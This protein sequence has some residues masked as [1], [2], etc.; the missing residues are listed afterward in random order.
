MKGKILS[1]AVAV[2]RDERVKEQNYTKTVYGDFDPSFSSR[3]LLQ[4]SFFRASD[5]TCTYSK[6]PL[7]WL[8]PFLYSRLQ[9]SSMMRGFSIRLK[10]LVFFG[11]SVLWEFLA[12]ESLHV[13]T[14]CIW[15]CEHARFCMECF[16]ALYVNCHS[17]INSQK[18]RRPLPQLSL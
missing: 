4:R 10:Q 16:Y 13:C 18:T 12:C 15:R 11:M 3:T 6:W 5:C 8:S 7:T 17:S 14:V 9:S 2:F 1:T